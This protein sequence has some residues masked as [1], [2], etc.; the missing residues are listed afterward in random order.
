MSQRKETRRGRLYIG[1]MRKINQPPP[2]PA[3]HPEMLVADLLREWPQTIPV[4]LHYR[5]DCVGCSMAAFERL[6]DAARIYNV[7]VEAF[8][9]SLEQSIRQ[10]TA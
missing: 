1:D 4:F 10:P 9:E 8:F 3:I 6:A 2:R 7:P 5:M